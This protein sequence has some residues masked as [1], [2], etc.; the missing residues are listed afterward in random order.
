MSNLPTNVI[1]NILLNSDLPTINNLCKSNSQIN[2]ICQNEYFW[3]QKYI[4]DY[5]MPSTSHEMISWKNLYKYR[6]LSMPKRG[7]L[8]LF[9]NRMIG[10]ITD[11]V[12]KIFDDMII[13]VFNENIRTS[14]LYQIGNSIYE[15]VTL[16]RATTIAADRLGISKEEVEDSTGTDRA[17][18]NDIYAQ[19]RR[20]PKII[21]KEDV[22][23]TLPCISELQYISVF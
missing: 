8:L 20:N 22:N 10:V 4:K 14:P 16:Q 6:N 17:V 5:G 13:V 21:T 15:F 2:N 1:F 12:S 11:E 18:Y 3:R 19:L 7:N 9:N 23:N